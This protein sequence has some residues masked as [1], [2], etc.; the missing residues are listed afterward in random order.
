MSELHEQAEDI[1]NRAGIRDAIFDGM[2][3]V[4]KQMNGFDAKYVKRSEHI[5]LYKRFTNTFQRLTEARETEKQLNNA[6]VKA[7]IEREAARAALNEETRAKMA[8]AQKSFKDG[9]R[10]GVVGACICCCLALIV[11]AVLI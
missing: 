2:K 7:C 11:I 5:A 3:P 8:L 9:V 4:M 6:Y 1:R 10:A